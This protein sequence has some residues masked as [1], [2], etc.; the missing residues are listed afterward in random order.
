MGCAPGE[1]L[2]KLPSSLAYG[3]RAILGVYAHHEAIRAHV[4]P[5]TVSYSELSPPMVVC[6]R[7]C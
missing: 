4:V 5:S 1:L 7:L 2:A 6:R 3:S